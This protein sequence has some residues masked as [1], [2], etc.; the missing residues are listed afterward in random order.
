[1]SVT[2]EE[3]NAYRKGVESGTMKSATPNVVR[4][5]LDEIERLQLYER[6]MQS[7]ARQFICPQ[8]TAE[9]LARQQVGSWCE[10]K[11]T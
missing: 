8:I 1:M 9:E 10:E 3:L 6:A 4:Q 5:L 2:I 11:A 7:M